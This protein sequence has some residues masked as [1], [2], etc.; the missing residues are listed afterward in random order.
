MR[1]LFLRLR[2]A[3]RRRGLCGRFSLGLD[4]EASTINRERH[5]GPTDQPEVS[6][7]SRARAEL[8]VGAVSL[9]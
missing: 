7:T 8:S 3:A 6:A 4:V 9:Y 2:V 5:R 1:D